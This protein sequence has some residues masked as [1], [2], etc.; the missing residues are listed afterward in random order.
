MLPNPV[1]RFLSSYARDALFDI[2][3]EKVAAGATGFLGCLGFF[4]SRLLRNWPLAM[5]VLLV[6]ISGF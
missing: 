5:L 4:A 2:D 6:P 1:Y 3:S